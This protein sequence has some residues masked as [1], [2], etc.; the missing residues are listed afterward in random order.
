MSDTE[1]NTT[2]ENLPATDGDDKALSQEP[3]IKVDHVQ[4]IFNMASEQLQSFKEYFIKLAKHEL[5]FKEFVALDDISFEVYPGEVYGLVGTN[6]SGKSTMLKIIAGVLEPSKGTCT[7]HGV[8]APLIELGAG[9]DMELTARENIFLNG[10]LLGYSKEYLTEHFDEIVEFAEIES[11]L[12][13]PLKNYSSGMVARIAFA[14]ATVI[15]PDIL[16]V[17]EALSVGDQF[18]QEKC[19]NRIRELIEKHHVTVLFVSHNVEQV[20]RICDKAIWIEQGQMRMKGKAEDICNVYGYRME[21]L[22]VFMAEKGSEPELPTADAPDPGITLGHDPLFRVVPHISHVGWR[23]ADEG[24]PG[25][26]YGDPNP[27]HIESINIW[28]NDNL[29]EMGMLGSIM[30]NVNMKHVGWE[31]DPN[32]D[33]RTTWTPAGTMTGSVESINKGIPVEQV[34]FAL[35]GEFEK[36]YDIYYRVFSRGLGWLDWKKNGEPA[37]IEPFVSTLTR[38]R[39]RKRR[40]NS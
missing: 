13:M 27:E 15:I 33:D 35:T 10:A 17:D 7:T 20:R 14:I 2:E 5:R 36:R 1:L 29:V 30:C 8:I 38:E 40:G 39:D 28:P 22:Q 26:S 4:M 24:V 9:F 12:E 6:G 18:F 25:G 3:V 11:F 23:E 31:H 34:Q 21:G 16:I 19:E 32:T 37:G